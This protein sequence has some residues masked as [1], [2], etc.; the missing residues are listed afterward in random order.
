MK[1]DN[2]IF[3]LFIVIFV[4]EFNQKNYSQS[5]ENRLDS[6]TAYAKTLQDS[7]SELSAELKNLTEKVKLLGMN[8]DAGSVGKKGWRKLERY[9]SI[10][11]VKKLLGKP[12][13]IDE[14]GSSIRF[15]YGNGYINFNAFKKVSDWSE[16]R[17]NRI[18]II[19]H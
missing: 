7:I 12:T 9:M 14:S 18:E 1:I 6:L 15:W 8:Y 4:F 5:K 11:A 17:K 19:E 2:K 10:K 13:S 16:P 3:W